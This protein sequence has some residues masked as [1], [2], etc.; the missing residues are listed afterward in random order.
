MAMA[1]D[2]RPIHANCARE[3]NWDGEHHGLFVLAFEEV[4]L[5]KTGLRLNAPNRFQDRMKVFLLIKDKSGS[6][7]SVSVDQRQVQELAWPWLCGR[8]RSQCFQF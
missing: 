4:C 1:R 3:R 6:H 2:Q 5:R 8:T 7:E